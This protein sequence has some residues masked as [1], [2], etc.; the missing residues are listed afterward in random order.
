M[1]FPLSASTTCPIA[2]ESSRSVKRCSPTGLLKD[3]RVEVKFVA[4]TKNITFP[5]GGESQIKPPFASVT[6]CH[7][8]SFVPF[9]E[10]TLTRA[11][12]IG[13]WLWST[14]RPTSGSVFT[15]DR[16]NGFISGSTVTGWSFGLKPFACTIS[17]V[18][19]GCGTTKENFPASSHGIGFLKSG[20][21]ASTI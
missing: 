8:S 12:A 17:V 7:G 2:R 3:I 11:P 20:L 18:S 5:S 21:E 16:L 6:V 1:G 19:P 13:S 14:T 9:H 15:S 10:S 4:E